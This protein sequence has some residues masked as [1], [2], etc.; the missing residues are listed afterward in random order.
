MVRSVPYAVTSWT[1]SCARVTVESPKASVTRTAYA[2]SIQ[3]GNLGWVDPAHCHGLGAVRVGGV[4]RVAARYECDDSCGEILVDAGLF[5]DFAAD[6]FLELLAEFE[7]AAGLGRSP[8]LVAG[9]PRL[10][11]HRR[12]REGSLPREAGIITLHGGSGIRGRFHDEFLICHRQTH[13]IIMKRV[14]RR[15]AGPARPTG[16]HDTVRAS[17]KPRS[18]IANDGW[19]RRHTEAPQPRVDSAQPPPRKMR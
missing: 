19:L 16:P 4:E 15:T 12:P 1:P 13:N 11:R 14:L 10:P 9:R 18:S 2:E 3:F 8:M 7:D 6:A 5:A 17:R